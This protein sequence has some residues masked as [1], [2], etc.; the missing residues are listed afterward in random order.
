MEPLRAATP[1]LDHSTVRVLSLQGLG[2]TPH[3]SCAS[4]ELTSWLLGSGTWEQWDRRATVKAQSRLAQQR[5]QQQLISV[6][7]ENY[8][9]IA[10]FNMWNNKYRFLIFVIYIEQKIQAIS[11]IWRCSYAELPP[12]PHPSAQWQSCKQTAF[13]RNAG[14]RDLPARVLLQCTGFSTAHLMLCLPKLRL[15]RP[16][17]EAPQDG[18]KKTHLFHRAFE[19]PSRPR[20]RPRTQTDKWSSI[21]FLRLLSCQSTSVVLTASE[22]TLKSWSQVLRVSYFKV[23]MYKFKFEFW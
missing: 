15:S 10:V 12:P 21:P 3:L 7:S 2:V 5:G 1:S 17:S 23:N 19:P 11:V 8:M 9:R 13:C 20:S 22:W 18:K 4:L 16:L 14:L 6:S